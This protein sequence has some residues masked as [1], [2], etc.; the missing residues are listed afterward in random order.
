MRD[1]S[2]NRNGTLGEGNFNG[3]MQDKNTSAGAGVG[4]VDTRT[5]RG[6]VQL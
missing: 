5:L 2:E 6:E 4:N 1:E 3:G